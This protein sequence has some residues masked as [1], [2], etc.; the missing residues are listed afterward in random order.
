MISVSNASAQSYLSQNNS[1]HYVH[2]RA[3]SK[4]FRLRGQ[5][6]SLADHI[7]I[8]N[9]LPEGGGVRSEILKVYYFHAIALSK[10]LTQKKSKQR[11]LL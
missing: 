4:E 10:F 7:Y 3:W 9:L 8:P 1:K 5:V 2:C 6:G 11:S